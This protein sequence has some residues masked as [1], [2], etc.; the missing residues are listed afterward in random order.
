MV[1]MDV[2][3]VATL[4]L[5]LSPTHDEPSVTSRMAIVTLV[6]DN[7]TSTETVSL[8]VSPSNVTLPGRGIVAGAGQRRALFRL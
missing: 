1:R 3:S 5:S 6:P 4:A 2:T 7:V 8:P